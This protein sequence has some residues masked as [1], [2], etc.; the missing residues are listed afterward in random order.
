LHSAPT[1]TKTLEI[2]NVEAPLFC[3]AGKNEIAVTGLELAIKAVG[4]ERVCVCLNR[5]DTG[6]SSWQPSLCR[7]AQ[8]YGIQICELSD[9]R[10][11]PNLVF[12]SLEFDRIIRPSE[13][14]SRRLYNIHFSLLPAYK[15]VYTAAWPIL[16][17]ESRSGVTLHEI[18]AG[19]DTGP[20]IEQREFP[21]TPDCTARDVYFNCM[22]TASLLLTDKFESIAEDRLTKYPQSFEKST[23]YGRQSINYSNVHIETSATALQIQ[24][25]IRAM[26]FREFQTPHIMGFPV[27]R[28]EIQ[29]SRSTQKPGT[30]IEDNEDYR[31]I[32]T[33]DFDIV[34][35]RDHSN[36]YFEMVHSADPMAI[37]HYQH[38]NHHID[39]VNIKGWTPLIISAYNGFPDL[40]AALIKKGA[41]VNQGN[42]NGTT[43]IMF[44][45]DYAMRTGDTSVIRV[46]LQYSA[47]TQKCDRFGLT[48]FDYLN[49]LPVDSPNKQTVLQALE[50]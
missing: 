35:Y 29:S 9:I 36:D 21:I 31:R 34:C 26:H 23:Y 4:K 22:S 38:G 25:Q 19:I 45:K 27:S 37:E 14:A 13:F 44:A 12:L 20:I 32:A 15:G 7:F 3:I 40:C 42:A 18:D 49:R 2:F 28:T 33:I 6:Q 11:I 47:S 39:W 16:N 50:S 43:P 41:D 5:N 8:E 48:V 46:L 10:R 1:S 17:G 24:R 30:I